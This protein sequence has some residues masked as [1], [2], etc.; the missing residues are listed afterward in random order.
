MAQKRK[1]WVIC[2]LVPL[3]LLLP[4]LRRCAAAGVLALLLAR[5]LSRPVDTFERRGIPRW[6]S[7]A[8]FLLLGV[9][10][11][12]LLFSFAASRLCAALD[13]ITQRFPDLSTLFDR[14][15]R[16]AVLF[17]DAVAKLLLRLIGLLRAQSSA[18]PLRVGKWAA[19]VSGK[20]LSALPEK[21]F[22]LLI[23]VLSG[24]YALCDWHAL[25]PMLLSLIPEDWERMLRTVAHSLG[26]GAAGWLRAQGKL[27]LCQFT[28]LTAGLVLLGNRSA[29]PFAALAALADALPLL[30]SG[31]VL[32]PWAFFLWV[33]GKPVRAVGTLSLAALAWLLRTFLEPRLV[34]KQA[35]VMPFFTLLAMYLGLLSF[36]FW[37]LVAAPMLLTASVQLCETLKKRRPQ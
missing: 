2:L 32:I 6:L 24:F 30:G 13:S 15:E 26:A 36:G 19:R 22:F 31:A 12:V 3:F 8:A 37:G 23:S 10:L 9:L 11:I 29:I 14:L 21:L 16:F 18:L 5:F 27:M 20:A 33:E 17:P 28:L 7:G 4:P 35:G 34:G 1:K 25:R